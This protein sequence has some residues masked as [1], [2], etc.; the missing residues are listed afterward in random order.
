M[1]EHVVVP[2]DG[3]DLSA[4]ALPVALKICK[5]SGAALRVVSYVAADEL[6]S[7]RIRVEDQVSL[8][9]STAGP[10]LTELTIAVTSPM[11]SIEEELAATVARW[12]RVVVCMATHGRSRSEAVMGSVA[13]RLLQFVETPIVLV[14]PNCDSDFFEPDG[15]LVVAIDG[16]RTSE[17][18]LAPA[19]WWA[20]KFGSPLEL[21]T[22]LAPQTARVGPPEM[23]KSDVG[24]SIQ[25]ERQARIA[26]KELGRLVNFE[27]LHGKK[28]AK[29]LLEHLDS[30][31]AKIMAMATHGSTGL[32]RAAAGS[33][34]SD[35]VRKAKCPVLVLRPS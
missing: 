2:L 12:Q 27:V 32:S 3:S 35:V 21:V 26:Q 17:T 15:P 20:A 9:T 29:A 31:N 28:P 13:S 34:T 24:E 30:S 18:I 6:D 14:G 5:A 4:S 11:L 19:R 8:A 1:F 23:T 25:V 33:V 7:R 16:G 22:V 10:G